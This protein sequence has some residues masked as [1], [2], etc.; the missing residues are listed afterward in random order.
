MNRR[1]R[2]AAM[3]RWGDDGSEPAG[4]NLREHRIHPDGLL[5]A[6][7]E[8]VA[9]ELDLDTML[10]MDVAVDGLH[11]DSLASVRGLQ[12]RGSATAGSGAGDILL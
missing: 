7:H 11:R 5:E 6:R 3:I 8:L 2:V 9:V 10:A 12:A 1:D 4:D